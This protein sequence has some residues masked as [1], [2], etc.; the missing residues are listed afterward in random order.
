MPGP[1][2]PNG[3]HQLVAVATRSGAYLLCKVCD[4]REV[5]TQVP[6]QE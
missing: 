2:C 5:V 3:S 1:T 6:A 4:H